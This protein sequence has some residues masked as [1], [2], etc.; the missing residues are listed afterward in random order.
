MCLKQTYR[1]AASNYVCMQLGQEVGSDRDSE[2]PMG[3]KK[4]KGRRMCH[5]L[6]ANSQDEE[7]A[8]SPE[9]KSGTPGEG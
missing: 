3:V 4:E 6:F 2:S 5:F 9:K 8:E 7:A 1:D